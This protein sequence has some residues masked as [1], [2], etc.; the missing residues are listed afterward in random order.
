MVEVRR[1]SDPDEL[2]RRLL[3][4]VGRNLREVDADVVTTYDLAP[5]FVAW[6]EATLRNLCRI[7]GLRVVV[8]TSR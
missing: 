6:Q 3:P 5:A 4:L 1:A 8:E 2:D 7:A